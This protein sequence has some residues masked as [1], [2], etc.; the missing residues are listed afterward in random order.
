MLFD[1]ATTTAKTVTGLSG[2]KSLA[3]ESVTTYT[4]QPYTSILLTK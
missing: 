4:L 1:Y 3:D 2:W